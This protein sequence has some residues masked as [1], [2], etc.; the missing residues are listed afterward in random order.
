MSH[1]DD[2]HIF[3][4]H[5]H[6]LKTGAVGE[7]LTGGAD[8]RR[9]LDCD[10][11]SLAENRLGDPRDPRHL[12]DALRADWQSRATE[13]RPWSIQARS[14]YE[15]CYWLHEG[16]E[17]T[18]T[19][20]VA[21]STLGVAALR[22][23][24]FYVLPPHR[25][26]GTG[27]R[28]L[29]RLQEALALHDLGLR[30][31]TS[32]CWQPAVR[33]YLSAGLW[34]YM[35]KRELTFCWFPGTPSPRFDVG[36]TDA[37]LS[38]ACDGEDVV[39]ARA[40]RRGEALE[41]SLPPR[42]LE[43]DRRL[44]EAYWHAASTFSLALAQH[45]WPLVRSREEWDESWH[46]DGGAPE[47]LAYK[48]VLWEAWARKHGWLVNTPRI[49]GVDYPTWDELQARWDAEREAFEANLARKPD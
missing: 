10:L 30:L 40:R 18:G 20:A 2:Q 49:P 28:A 21:T 39:L 32:W 6:L 19:I 48:I 12:D 4:V 9:W 24:S 34:V 41:L 13:E 36:P 5:A 42:S 25:G 31:D 7:V 35:W 3:D 23:S 37:T 15:R 45:G 16:G 47:A 26:R 1:R 33:F 46:A 11:A 22:I 38:V 27:K 17:R 29:A 14:R 43:S 8:E 44:G